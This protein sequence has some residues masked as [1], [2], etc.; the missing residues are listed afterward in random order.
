M[1]RA[2]GPVA[3]AWG[4]RSP[5]LFARGRVKCGDVVERVNPDD[6]ESWLSSV[7]AEGVGG[8]LTDDSRGTE[9]TLVKDV[10]RGRM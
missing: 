10:K 4:K 1:L 7:S 8:G 6:R 2:G 5:P 3:V 9:R